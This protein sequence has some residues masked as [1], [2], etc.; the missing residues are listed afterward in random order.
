[1]TRPGDFMDPENLVWYFDED[2]FEET[3]RPGFRRR[4]ITGDRMQ[5]CFWRIKGGAEGS[6]LHHHPE[7]EQL[8]VVVKGRLELR[9]GDPET[10]PRSSLGP[11]ELYIAPAGVW[12]GDSRF[13]GDDELDECWILDVFVPP[14][15]DWGTSE[16]AGK[17][18][19]GES[20]EP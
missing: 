16:E 15:E 12:H 19:Y 7:H 20:D 11:G 8:G 18:A 6:V 10:A 9:I 17:L 3:D 13:F 1:M 5:L 4:I 2:T 14:R